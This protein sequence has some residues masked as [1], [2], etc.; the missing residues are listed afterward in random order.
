MQ[1]IQSNPGRFVSPRGMWHQ[2]ALLAITLAVLNLPGIADTAAGVPPVDAS[3]AREG[4]RLLWD[5]RP[6]QLI[7][8]SYYGLVG[9]RAFDAEGFLDVLAAHNINFTRFFCILPWPVESG[10][11][12][13]PF[14]RA[15]DKY[16]LRRFDEGYFARLGQVVRAAEQR[17][18]VCQVCLFDRCGLSVGDAR[19]WNNNP[20]NTILNVNGVLDGKGGS[21]PAFCSMEGKIA[22]ING[23]FIEKVVSTLGVCRNVIYE[24]MNEPYPQLGSLPQWH[25]WVA[26]ELRR[27]LRDRPGSKVIAANYFCN[28]P[29]IDLLSMHRAG[30]DKKVAAAL[31]QARVLGKP[32]ILSDDGDLKCMYD[33]DVTRGAAHRAMQLGQH[34]EHLAFT[35]TLQREVEH[36]PAARW[37]ELPGL[38]RMNLGRL[39]EVSTP[40][41]NRPYV[42]RMEVEVAQHGAIVR[43]WVENA[44]AARDIAVQLR[45]NPQEDWESIGSTRHDGIL[46]SA[47]VAVGDN[48]RVWVRVRLV[49]GHGHHWN[50]PERELLPRHHHKVVLGQEVIESGMIRVRANVA[51]GAMRRAERQGKPC[52]ETMPARGG[53]YAYF[54]VHDWLDF[55]PGSGELVAEIEYFDTT[56]SGR[57]VLEYDTQDTPYQAA[58]A[59]ALSGG[60]TWRTA[61]FPLVGAVLQGRQNDGADLRFSLQNTDNPLAIRAVQLSGHGHEI[62]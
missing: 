3:I 45:R 23:A 1:R 53:K 31:E 19:A 9:D 2:A 50:G 5:G 27:H 22:E 4:T 46:I 14:P 34:F 32:L 20:Y 43:A 51:D 7:G 55:P 58:P 37:W 25:A 38:C 59:V 35:L 36:R 49:D 56:P 11:N 47:P 24:I 39:A 6:V 18:I 33:P 62:Q 29:E 48:V 21:Y 15:G 16:D 61:S 41:I 60:N 8:F 17:G 52:Y 13:L 30:D 44:A 12:L 28:D 54:R 10:P 57:L 42:G 40:L 26:H